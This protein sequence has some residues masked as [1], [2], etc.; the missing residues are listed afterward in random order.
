[1]AAAVKGIIWPTYLEDCAQPCWYVGAEFAPIFACRSWDDTARLHRSQ[2][3]LSRKETWPLTF[4]VFRRPW[5][6]PSGRRRAF[7]RP[8]EAFT[9]TAR[10]GKARSAAAEN[11]C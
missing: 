3:G 10:G 7:H 2:S 5:S 11:V 8:S 4:Y 1:M 6:R 9:F